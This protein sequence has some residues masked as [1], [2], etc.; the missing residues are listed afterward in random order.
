LIANALWTWLFFVW[1]QGALSFIE[2]VIL[3]LLIATTLMAFWRLHKIAALLL[4]PYLA[5]VSLATALTYFLWQHNP[6]VLGFQANTAQSK[7]IKNDEKTMTENQAIQ[8]KLQAKKLAFKNQFSPLKSKMLEEGTVFSSSQMFSSL[9]ALKALAQAIGEQS[10]EL[11]T[12]YDML[13]LLQFKRD[14]DDE[15][16]QFGELALQINEVSHALTADEQVQ[17]HNILRKIYQS[18]EN[19]APALKHAQ[20]AVAKATTNQLLTPAQRLGLQVSLGFILHEQKQ[21]ALA[22]QTNQQTLQD[23]RKMYADNAIELGPLLINIAQNLYMLDRTVDTK[24]YLDRVLQIARQHNDTELEFDMLFQMGVLRYEDHDDA[25]AKHYFDECMQVANKV[26]DE[27]L[28]NK[29][30]D[31]LKLLTEKRMPRKP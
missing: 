25:M 5:W 18:H 4:I 16:L 31:Y 9:M 30:Q 19:Y 6:V 10:P 13:A 7:T 22:L 17:T 29:A 12:L 2:I 27:N 23:A 3:W 28:Q 1:H 24:V 11:T 26:K 15:A 14:I 8:T 20:Q 21:Y